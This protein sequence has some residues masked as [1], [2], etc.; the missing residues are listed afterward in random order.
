MT[1]TLTPVSPREAPLTEFFDF[2]LS[3]DFPVP[4]SSRVDGRS[5]VLACLT[6][7]NGR[8]PV[9]LPR[10]GSQALTPVRA[11]SPR[12]LFY[13]TLKINIG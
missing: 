5:R 3:S 4:S 9:P 10:G 6:V 13:M 8:P 12:D 7:S 1:E 2:F 11:T